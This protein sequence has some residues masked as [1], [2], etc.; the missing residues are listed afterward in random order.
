MMKFDSLKIA[1]LF[2]V[3]FA[4]AAGG[5]YADALPTPS[6]AGPLAAN[7]SP[8]KFDGGPLGDIY[9]TGAISGLALYQSNHTET[10]GDHE[11]LLDF[12]NAQVIVQNTTGLLQFYVQA[13]EYSLPTLGT[14]YLRATSATND[15]GPVPVAYLKLVPTDTFNI[16]AGKLPTLIGAEYTF[17]FQNLNIERGLL[18]N[19]EPAV[20]RGV[21]ANYTMGPL[22]FSLAWTDGAYT[23]KYNKLSGSAAWTISPSDTVSLVGG[24]DVGGP[25]KPFSPNLPIDDEQVYNLIWTHTSGP[26]TITPYGQY[27]SIEGNTFVHPHHS[28]TVPTTTTWGGAILANYAFDSNWSLGGRVEYISQNDG[29]DAVLYGKNS[30]AWTITVTPTYQYKVLFARADFSY[31]AAS[32]VNHHGSSLGYPGGFGTDGTATDQTRVMLEVGV[33]F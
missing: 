19:Q 13:G 33:L 18:W 23:N 27:T 17:T 31:V 32:D 20:S 10:V 15:F 14:P 2:G 22:A 28:Y 4:L 6:M 24:G 30:S 1:S 16:E 26:W 8:M 7:A 12:T 11:T 25:T 29:Y 5:A 3:A 9:V 21:Q